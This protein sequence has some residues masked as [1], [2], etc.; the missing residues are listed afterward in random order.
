MKPPLARSWGAVKFGIGLLTIGVLLAGC[1]ASRTASSP[2]ASARQNAAAASCAGLRPAQELAA[3][4]LVFLGRMLPGPSAVV[5]GREV[6]GSPAK[7]RVMRYLKGAGPRTVTVSS[8]VTITGNGL[9]VAEDGIE[10][11]VGEVWKLYTRSREQPYETSTCGGSIRLRSTGEVALEFWNRFPAQKD[12][13]PVIALG[14]GV[15]LDPRTGFPNDET[16]IAY[17]EGRF[18]LRAA[19]PSGPTAADRLPVASA[20]DAF[21][22]LRAIGRLAGGKVAPLIIHAVRLGTAIFLTDRG[23]RRLPA[24]QFFFTHIARPA[25]VLALAT[26]R[27]FT[28]PP[29]QQLGPTGPGNSIED[30]ARENRTETAIAISFIGAPPGNGPCDASYSASAV[31]DRR[32]VAFTI[33]THSQLAPPQTVCAAVGY[34]RTTVLHL[35]RPLGRRVLISSTDAG[36]VPV[37]R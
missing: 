36:A 35:P 20:A 3:A 34:T 12:P 5:D 23:P 11:Q 24:W 37:T 22:R 10:P 8:A 30:S 15:V 18:V 9:T 31:Q 6:L 16:K 13:R 17:S 1:A 2:V 21:D 4:R 14:Q 27:L 7:V 26:T 19:L 29:L 33:T 28:P 32:A 25:L